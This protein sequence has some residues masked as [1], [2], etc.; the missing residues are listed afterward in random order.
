MPVIKIIAFQ[1]TGGVFNSDSPYYG[2]EPGLVRAGHVGL[3]GVIPDKIIGFAPTPEAAEVAGGD[4]P[5]L[6]MLGEYVAQEGRLQNSL[7]VFLRA[8]ELIEETGGR[9]TIWELE[10]EVL[11]ICLNR[12][13]AWYNDKCRATYNF[14]NPRIPGEFLPRV[15]QCPWI[16]PWGCRRT[17]IMQLDAV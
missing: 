5:L 2:R 12:I 14:P 1:G 17:A 7:E 6:D 15:R 3:E 8:L 13:R 11:D 9:T 4:Q 16:H 10:I